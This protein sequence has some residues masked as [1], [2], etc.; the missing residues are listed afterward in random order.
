MGGSQRSWLIQQITELAKTCRIRG[1]ASD[2]EIKA[3]FPSEDA[4]ERVLIIAYGQF[5]SWRWVDD[6][7]SGKLDAQDKVM[8]ALRDVPA[9][10][11]L[12]DGTEIKVY[13]KSMDCLLWFR[14]RDWLLGYLTN[15]L[16]DL[17]TAIASGSLPKTIRQPTRLRDQIVS[18]LATQFA[19]IAGC[20]TAEGPELQKPVKPLE[21]LTP[22]DYYLLHQGFVE[23]N[24]SRLLALD[25]IVSPTGGKGHT[26]WNVFYG[27]MSQKLGVPAKELMSNQSLASLVTEARL[28]TPSLEDALASN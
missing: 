19:L 7:N 14:E 18:E 17:K 22:I 21:G 8:A 23:C 9:T 20:C 2:E 5:R 12:T 3:A 4:D 28:A 16:S 24:S 27:T 1:L 13:P 6:L 26:G 25:N 15:F 11:M 10:V